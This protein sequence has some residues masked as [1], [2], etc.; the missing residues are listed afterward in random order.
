M[1]NV[2]EGGCLTRHK[3]N[4]HNILS[5]FTVK[6]LADYINIRCTYFLAAVDVPNINGAGGGERVLPSG[7]SNIDTYY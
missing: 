2:K 3:F 4:D 6:G 7:T 5:S 1:D